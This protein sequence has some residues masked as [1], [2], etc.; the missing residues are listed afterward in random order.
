MMKPLSL[1]HINVNSSYRKAFF[2]MMSSSIV[3]AEG[4][5]N[6]ATIILRNDNPYLSEIIKEFTESIQLLNQKPE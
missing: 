5:I 2:T 6:F 4:V 3:D 1:E